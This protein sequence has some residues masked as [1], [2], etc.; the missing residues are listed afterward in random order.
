MLLLSAI[1]AL[2][3]LGEAAPHLPEVSDT[4]TADAPLSSTLSKTLVAGTHCLDGTP[5]GYYSRLNASST[6]WVIYLQGGGACSDEASC[7]SRS[8]QRLGSSTAWPA[9]MA[10]DGFL[11]DDTSANRDF[12]TANHVHIPYSTGDCHSG[13]RTEASADTY[14]LYFSGSRNFAS[15]VATLVAH[16]GL[17][18]ATHV[19]L[20]GGSAGGIGTLKQ[21]DNLAQMLG[22][23]VVVKGA[24]NAG[25]FFP[26]ETG[27]ISNKQRQPQLRR[28]SRWP[29]SDFAD[30][31]TGH[32][33]GWDN[34]T[35]SALVELWNS[36]L[37]PQCVAEQANPY[38][39]WNLDSLYPYIKQ[40]LFIIENQYQLRAMLWCRLIVG[41]CSNL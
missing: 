24:P 30:F 32:V 25:W 35:V 41:Y 8:K 3:L 21:V 27:D 14:G 37:N 4:A 34:E 23:S 10:G 17:D 16:S 28:T 36:I 6:T 33:G 39:C 19:L 1:A 5:A 40:P 7:K 15:I 11:S 26:A 22:P 12:A 18:R 9:T 20:T 29:P 2:P 31:A 38:V 13:N